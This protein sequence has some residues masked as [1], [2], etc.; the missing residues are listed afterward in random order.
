M[1][2][3]LSPSRKAWKLIFP[4]ELIVDCRKQ[5]ILALG[6][7]EH[8][9]KRRKLNQA[10][11]N[12]LVQWTGSDSEYPHTFENRTNSHAYDLLRQARFHC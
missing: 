12:S 3:S 2:G 6:E 9:E 10:R 11:K 8:T 1:K 7:K 4:P 5:T